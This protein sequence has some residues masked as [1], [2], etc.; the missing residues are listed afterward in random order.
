MRT[1]GQGF[2][3]TDKIRQRYAMT[4]RDDSTGLDH[5][6]WRKYENTS[7]RWISPDPYLGNITI[8]DPQ[9]FNRYAYTQNDPVNFTDPSGLELCLPFIGCIGITTII[10]YTLA[11]KFPGVGF[12]FGGGRRSPLLAAD[13]EVGGG[14]GEQKTAQKPKLDPN[15]AECLALARK[16]V[17]IREDLLHRAD[18]ILKNPQNLPETAPGPRRNSIQGHREIL[19]ENLANYERRMQ[20][21]N[22]KCGGPPPPVRVMPPL[23]LPRPNSNPGPRMVPVP[24]PALPTFFTIPFI[25]MDPCLVYPALCPN[26]LKG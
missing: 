16:I 26:G 5:T 11:P 21:Y 13:G 25:M 20:E 7:G 24:V 1:S 22:D 19:K 18:D 23:V 15:N 8:T 2:G 10:T 17:N 14:A 6:W 12:G 4:E 9:S 3:V